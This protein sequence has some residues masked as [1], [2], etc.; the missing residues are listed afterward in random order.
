MDIIRLRLPE[1]THL[2]YKA[3]AA[4]HHLPLSTYLRQ[5]LEEQDKSQQQLE[6]LEQQLTKIEKSIVHDGSSPSSDS[7]FLLYEIILLLRTIVNPG[8]RRMV[9][10]ELERQGIPVW[11][12]TQEPLS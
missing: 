4:L 11:E 3:Q 9:H 5:R 6:V 2:F 10:S 12:G 8:N 7:I 1:Q